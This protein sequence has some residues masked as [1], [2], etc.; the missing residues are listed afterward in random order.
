MHQGRDVLYARLTYCLYL[1][2][3]ASCCCCRVILLSAADV[4]MSVLLLV[5]KPTHSPAADPQPSGSGS[6]IPSPVSFGRFV[7][8]RTSGP[9]SGLLCHMCA[10]RPQ[11]YIE[12]ASCEYARGAIPRGTHASGIR[13]FLSHRKHTYQLSPS[14][15]PAARAPRRASIS[16]RDRGVRREPRAAPGRRAGLGP[17]RSAAR[18]A[19]N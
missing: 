5:R 4:G 16:P 17:R 8:H 18:G 12:H 13:L 11:L 10:P 6:S 2:P 15:G 9:P 3:L 19:K 1:R 7:L 14:G